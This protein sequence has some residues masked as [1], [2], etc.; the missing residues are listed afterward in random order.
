MAE[1]KSENYKPE[2][3]PDNA[4]SEFASSVMPGVEDCG[5]PVAAPRSF[6]RRE[7]SVDEYVEGV[8]RGDRRILAQA[9]TVVESNSEKH[10]K[11][12]QER[13]RR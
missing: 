2:W 13:I 4:G 12:G 9:I 5:A 11:H 7:I 8:L 6:K 3:T 10:F 1:K